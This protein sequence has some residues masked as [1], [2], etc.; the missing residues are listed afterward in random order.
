MDILSDLTKGN[1]NVEAIR[2][3]LFDVITLPLYPPAKAGIIEVKKELSAETGKKIIIP[4]DAKFK[5]PTNFANYK[6]TGGECLGVLGKDWKPTQPVMLLDAFE[7]CLI[8][9]GMDLSQMKYQEL[10]G[11]RKVRFSVPLAETKFKNSAKVGDVLK[12]DLVIQT[13]FD[14]FT[15]TSFM[16][17]TLVLKCT[18]GMT[19]FGTEASVKFKNTK[20]NVGKIAIAC[21]DIAQMVTKADDFGELMKQYDKTAVTAKNVDAFLKATIGYSRKERDEL[22]KVKTERLDQIQEAIEV[23]F[24]RNGKTAWGLLNAMTYATNH[25]WT[26]EESQLDYLTNG[27]GLRTNNK[28]Q[29]F[30]NEL[31]LS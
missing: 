23:E 25:I 16:I 20:H 8:D 1:A 9:S 30:L 26:T 14:G 2:E 12:K 15:A 3:Q 11:G 28:A 6:N 4:K 21:T 29:K 13:G 19:G 24:S 10:K 5:R 22:G 7:Q 18:N 31:V 27:A 17:E